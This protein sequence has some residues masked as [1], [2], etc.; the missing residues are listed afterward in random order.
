MRAV[1]NACDE[2]R[3]PLASYRR[4]GIAELHLPI[5]DDGEPSAE[6]VERALAFLREHLESKDR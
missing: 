6:Q 3:G 5:L 4:F 2:Y 1:I